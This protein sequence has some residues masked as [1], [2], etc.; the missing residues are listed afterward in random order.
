MIYEERPLERIVSG[1]S[2]IYVEPKI[3]IGEKIGQRSPCDDRTFNSIRA[4][5][6]QVNYSK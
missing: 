6:S 3:N 1:T 4:N 2:P 5:N